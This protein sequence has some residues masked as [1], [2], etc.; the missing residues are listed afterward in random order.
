MKRYKRIFVILP[1]AALM[2][3]LGCES[4]N[5]ALN[6][7]LTLQQLQFKLQ[8]VEQFKV[9]GVDISRYT[10]FDDFRKAKFSDL[11]LAQGLNLLNNVSQKKF[12]VEFVLN[13]SARNPN[14]G[15]QGTQ[16]TQISIGSLE[17]KL[18]IDDV[19]TI[20]GVVSSPLQLPGGGKETIIP[21]RMAL[22]LFKFFENKSYEH[23]ANL[24]LAIGGSSGSPARLKMNVRPTISTPFGSYRYPNM[25]TV[26][27]KQ[28]N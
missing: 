1:A 2:I 8:N 21:F 11:S 4:L 18:Y 16:S 22:D 15:S 7:I 10:S 24:A 12:P 14:D 3:F 9:S 27:D 28:F 6:Q 25:I 17:W 23:I 5:K 20:N 19:E 13:V 26:V